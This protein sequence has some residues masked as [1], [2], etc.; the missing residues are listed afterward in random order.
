MGLREPADWAPAHMEEMEFHAEEQRQASLLGAD[1]C[2]SGHSLGLS[3]C[4]PSDSAEGLDHFPCIGEELEEQAKQLEE[5]WFCPNQVSASVAAAAQAKAAQAASRLTPSRLAVPALRHSGLDLLQRQ[6]AKQQLEQQREDQQQEDSDEELEIKAEA[7]DLAERQASGCYMSCGDDEPSTPQRQSKEA[8]W[9]ESVLATDGP[10]GLEYGEVQSPAPAKLLALPSDPSGPPKVSLCLAIHNA[11]RVRLGQEPS[12]GAW[13]GCGRSPWCSQEAAHNSRC[14]GCAAVPGL[15]AYPPKELFESGVNIEELCRVPEELAGP[16]APDTESE[17]EGTRRG[18]AADAAD[19][20]SSGKRR[21]DA[22]LEDC[23]ASHSQSGHC[24]GTASTGSASLAAALEA[25]AEGDEQQQQERE[26]EQAD[27]S[28][29]AKRLRTEASS[30]AGLVPQ[31]QPVPVPVEAAFP[32]LAGAAALLD[33]SPPLPD[34]V[35][36][37]PAAGSSSSMVQAVCS[38]LGC[39]GMVPVALPLP[40][41]VPQFA[42]PVPALGAGISRNRG[43][44]AGAPRLRPLPPTPAPSP[45]PP[46]A[47]AAAGPA[48]ASDTPNKPVTRQ[49]NHVHDSSAAPVVHRASGR[50]T[51]LQWHTDSV[52]DPRTAAIVTSV[53]PGTFCTQCF[54]LSTPVWRAG[55]FGHKTLCNA[56]GVRWMKHAKGSKK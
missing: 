32:L 34:L 56:C 40:S 20:L 14:D 2:L 12:V 37:A 22:D 35:C 7:D 6:L 49:K 8:S 45:L 46:A 5:D 47:A 42:P 55:P 31:L 53:Q 3:P 38:P 43:R 1:E 26:R 15:L 29:A 17:G 9:S 52:T 11:Q 24:G 23:G 19:C 13:R 16:L 4:E 18:T 28:H 30:S 41:A 44:P 48:T 33:S 54:A 10:S 50:R 51:V 39:P 36:S 27:G 25:A 21:A